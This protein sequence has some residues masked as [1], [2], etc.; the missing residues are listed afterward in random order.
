MNLYIIYYQIEMACSVIWLRFRNN[1]YG[2]PDEYKLVYDRDCD[3]ITGA[4]VF[5]GM[6]YRG[7]HLVMPRDIDIGMLREYSKQFDTYREKVIEILKYCH[8]KSGDQKYLDGIEEIYKFEKNLT[9][10][11]T[12]NQIFP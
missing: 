3:V 1:Y 7:F 5:N 11:E 8:S 10:Q 12:P 4:D 6:S 2:K 9:R